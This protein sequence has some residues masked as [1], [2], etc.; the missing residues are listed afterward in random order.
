MRGGAWARLVTALMLLVQG[1]C[2]QGKWLERAHRGALPEA[3]LGRA[4]ESL[5]SPRHLGAFLSQ[6]LLEFKLRLPENFLL[7][8]L[9]LVLV[10][11]VPCRS[12]DL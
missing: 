10:S 7:E 12:P 2:Q 4:A 8:S 11:F 3:E 1:K 6:L 5:A 9:G